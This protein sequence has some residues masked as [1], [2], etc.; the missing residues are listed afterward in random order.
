MLMFTGQISWQ[1]AIQRGKDRCRNPS[2]GGGDPEEEGGLGIEAA[3][4]DEDRELELE[5]DQGKR[6]G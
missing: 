4:V 2:R 5:V 3:I 1:R 6:T